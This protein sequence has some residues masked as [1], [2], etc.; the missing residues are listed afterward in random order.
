MNIYKKITKSIPDL[1]EKLKQASIIDTPLE[2]TKKTFM[3]ASLMAGAI[4]AIIFLMTQS[5]IAL[6]TFPIIQPIMLLYFI[7]Y[8]DVKIEQIRKKVDEEIIFAGRFLIIELDS[9]VP[10]HKAFEN[11]EKNYTYVGKYFGDIINKTYLGTSMEDAINDTLMNTPAPNLRKLLWQVLNSLKTGS[12]IAP[13]LNNVVDQIVKE[14]KIAV[15]EYGKKLNPMAM[16]YMMISVIVP[17][18]GTTMLVILATFLGLNLGLVFLLSLAA[19]VGFI[20][21]MFTI[22]IKSQRPPISME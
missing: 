5:L 3:T 20:Q 11:I 14:Q 1:D 7:K 4:S 8:V 12:E 22:M 17:S 16:F 10:M 18:L 21:L 19:F 6:L 13:A 2:Y 15:K 9:G